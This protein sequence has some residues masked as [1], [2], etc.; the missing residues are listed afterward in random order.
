LI[1]LRTPA[2]DISAK[3]IAK[4]FKNKHSDQADKT[5]CLYVVYC[6]TAIPHVN[7]RPVSGLMSGLLPDLRLPMTKHSGIK[8]ILFSFTVAG[9]VSALLWIQSKRT[10]FP[11]NSFGG[12]RKNT[13]SSY[14]KIQVL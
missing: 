8:Q 12:C 5:T 2:R 14:I 11:F 7:F 3:S 6:P 4:G 1:P 13:S 10:G 9:A